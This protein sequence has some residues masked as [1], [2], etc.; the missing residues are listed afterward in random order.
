MVDRDHRKLSVARQRKLLGL[1]RSSV[2]YRSAP[3]RKGDVELM[4]K[5]D[6][7]YTDCPFY[8]TRRMTRVLRREGVCINRK[9]V[10]RLMRLMGLEAQCPK[11]DLSRPAPGHTV[12]PYLMK[13]IAVERP[14]QAWRADITYIRLEDGFVYLAAI[15]DWFSRKALAWELS[16]TMD[17]AFCV[18]ALQRAFATHGQPEIFNTDQGCQ[19]T[20]QEWTELLKERGIRISMDGRGGALDNVF[21]ER[22]WRS[23][24]YEEACLT[25]GRAA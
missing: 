14:N 21:V 13:E 12:Y 18:N 5:I 4:R 2:Y 16:D 20:S 23:L 7:H 9:K 8:G 25:V 22:L 3:S 10:R 24:K 6:E 1:A 11:P 17:T 19:F 15:M